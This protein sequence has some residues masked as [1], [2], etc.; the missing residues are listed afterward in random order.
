MEFEQSMERLREIFIGDWED[1]QRLGISLVIALILLLAFIFIAKWIKKLVNKKLGNKL[2]DTLLVNFISVSVRTIIMIFGIIIV[3]RF[4]GLTGVVGGLLAGAGITAFII[5]FA[6]KDIGENFLAGI[7]LA[8]KRPFKVGDIVD[9]NGLRGKVLTLNLRD[10]QIKSFD[11]KD[12]FVPNASII[13]N[14]L[15]NFTI[16][17]FLAYNFVVGLDYGSDYS[18]AIALMKESI[19]QVKGVLGPPKVPTVV[20]TELTASTLNV[21]VTFWVDTYDREI[22]DV[23]VKSNAI[24]KVLTD[25]EKAGFN[26]PGDIIELKNHQGLP[27]KE[28]R[29]EPAE[30][31]K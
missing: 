20:I 14:A 29:N 31:K 24:L 9:I 28:E 16:D 21:T 26:M 25:L 30:P 1:L 5:G 4:L 8:F 3:M 15:I 6:L 22:S 2:E 7:L 18:R 17:G 11:G 12:I 13:K 27:L 10:T 19:T 23:Q